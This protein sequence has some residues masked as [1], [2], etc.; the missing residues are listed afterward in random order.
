MDLSAFDSSPCSCFF[1][2]R[3]TGSLS[4]SSIETPYLLDVLNDLVSFDKMPKLLFI[5]YCIFFNLGSS[6]AF[7]SL[8]EADLDDQA[9]VAKPVSQ[10]VNFLFADED[11]FKSVAFSDVVFA[12]SGNRVESIDLNDSI[13]QEVVRYVSNCIREILLAFEDQA[14]PIHSVGRVN[15]VSRFVEDGLVA[16]LSIEDGFS[17]GVPLNASGKAQR[18]GYPDIRLVHNSSG[19][20]Y[21]IDPKVYR[22]GSESSSFRTFYFEPKQTTSKIL[23]DARHLIIGLS[24]QGKVDGLWMF[25]S[26]KIVDLAHFKVRLK[27]EFQASNRDLYLEDL[28]IDQDL[29]TNTGA[30]LPSKLN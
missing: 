27:A 22:S 6:F 12:T 16:I 21:Y 28:V 20:V 9:S 13:D 25:R 4:S 8:E 11:A 24:H 30:L 26:W 3:S 19:R 15:E 29:V 23:E 1:P 18:S 5:L 10:L 7:Q 14:H 2:V 17:A